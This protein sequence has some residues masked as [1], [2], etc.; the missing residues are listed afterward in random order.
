MGG[1]EW[2]VGVAMCQL[3]GLGKVCNWGWDML[4][5]KRYSFGGFPCIGRIVILSFV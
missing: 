3:R 5:A 1:C 2:R 4:M